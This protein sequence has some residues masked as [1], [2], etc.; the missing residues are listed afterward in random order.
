MSISRPLRLIS[1]LV[2]IVKQSVLTLS[3]NTATTQ[4]LSLREVPSALILS[5]ERE[6]KIYKK[7]CDLLSLRQA[8]GL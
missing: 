2:E 6:K 5:L 1:D 8:K 7:E 3:N 4:I